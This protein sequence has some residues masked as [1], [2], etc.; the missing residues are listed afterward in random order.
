M[1]KGLIDSRSFS[2][3]AYATL[4]A[5][6]RER[7]Y[8]FRDYE[9]ASPDARHIIL[10]HDV[11]FSLE[12]ALMMAEREAGLGVK[13]TYFVLLRTEFY[14]LLSSQG[15]TMLKKIQQAGH[16]IGLHFDAALYEDSPSVID[17]AAE[18]ECKIVESA[19]E[20]PIDLISFHRPAR[21]LIA[22]QEYIG[23]RINAYGPKFV[24][25]MGYC[26]DSRGAWHYGP[27]LENEAIRDGRA[28]QLLVHPIWWQE[29][30]L[31]PAGQLARFL[32]ERRLFLDRELANH[33]SL[34][35]PGLNDPE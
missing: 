19:L 21:E 26:S 16:R 22:Q 2:P 4:I 9:K 1:N 28:L 30:I 27:P 31:S 35:Q 33:S 14:N 12:M 5:A 10:R 18:R 6:L 24:K 8:E 13:A 3:D 11:D 29:T 34:Y 25:D 32:E 7:G 17:T 20:G 23:G 15:L